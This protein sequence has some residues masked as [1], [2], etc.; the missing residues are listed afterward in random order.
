MRYYQAPPLCTAFPHLV[1]GF[2]EKSKY[3]KTKEE[4]TCPP[5]AIFDQSHIISFINRFAMVHFFWGYRKGFIRTPFL[6][7]SSAT[8]RSSRRTPRSRPLQPVTS[9][10]SVPQPRPPRTRCGAH[11]EGA[12]GGSDLPH[13]FSLWLP[14]PPRGGGVIRTVS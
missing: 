12:G 7:L 13:S 9:P 4:N 1:I 14:G 2:S 3:S 8:R 10:A 6:R 11:C 5:A